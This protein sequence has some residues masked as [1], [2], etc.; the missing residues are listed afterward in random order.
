MPLGNRVC[1]ALARQ[2]DVPAVIAAP[3]ADPPP[4][5]LAA[6]YRRPGSAHTTPIGVVVLDTCTSPVP[7]PPPKTRIPVTATRPWSVT[8]SA[9]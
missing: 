2:L 6:Q 1:L 4:N 7:A 9:V 8:L 5:Y 3:T